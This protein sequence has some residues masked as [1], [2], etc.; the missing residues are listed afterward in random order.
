VG[1]DIFPSFVLVTFYVN[2]VGCNVTW[3]SF[4]ERF[5]MDLQIKRVFTSIF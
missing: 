3:R 1:H 4:W 2:F 5:L